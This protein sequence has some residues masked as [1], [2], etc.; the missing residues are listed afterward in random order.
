MSYLRT[1][2]TRRL[3]VLLAAVVIG[4]GAVTAIALAATGSGTKPPPKPLAQAVQDALNAPQIKGVTARI[5]FTNRLVDSGTLRGSDPLLTGASGRL[6]ASGDRLRLELQAAPDTGAG[7]VQVLVAGRNLTVYESGSRTAYRMLLPK[8][9]GRGGAV[10]SLA[11]IQHAITRLSQRVALSGAI[12]SNVAGQPTYTARGEPRNNGGLLGGAEVSWDAENGVPLRA[13]VYAAGNSTPVLEFKAT[14]V[15]FGPV[16]AGD[17][18]PKLPAPAR[19]VNLDPGAGGRNSQ[20]G[21]E[22]TG[23]AAVRRRVGFALSA[24]STLAGRPRQEV[25]LVELKSAPGAL[26]TYGRGLGGIAVL[27]APARAADT[28]GVLG[29]GGPSLPSISVNGASGDELSTPLGTLIRFSRDG[30]QYT[31]VGSVPRAVA[32]AAAR[33]L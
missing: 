29:E 8:D 1:V 22:V 11:R 27:Q 12:P 6:W 31:V 28:G 17:L 5:S 3:L 10:P 15:S 33:G 13:A 30:V 26:V 18:A 23:L 20:G 2:S 14:D 24:P 19:T 7:D 16:P 25:R 4:A 9:R 32:E 21:R